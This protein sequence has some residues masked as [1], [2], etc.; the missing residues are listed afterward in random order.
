[1]P[2]DLSSSLNLTAE[3]KRLYGHLFRQADSE[4]IGVVTGEVAVKFFDKTRLEPRIL[5]EI[6]QIADKENRGLL[7]PAGFSLVLRLIGHCQAGREPTPELALRPG[8]LPKFESSSLQNISPIVHSPTQPPVNVLQPQPSGSGSIRVPPLTPEKARQYSALFDKSGAY[9]GVLPGEQAKQI[10]ERAGLPNETLGQIWNLADTEVKGAL[11]VTEFVIAMHLIASFKTGQL[12]V[13]PSALPFGLYEAAS[14]PLLTRSTTGTSAGLPHIQK[15]L[16]G[17]PQSSNT[18]SRPAPPQSPQILSHLTGSS[19]EWAISASDKFKFDSIYNTLDKTNQGYITG[20]EAV[21]F[22]SESKLSEEVLAQIWD[23]ADINSAGRLTKD[24]FAVAMYLIRQQRGK[25]DGRDMLP[26]RLPANLIP[27]SMRNQVRPTIISTIPVFD[28]PLPKLAKSATEDLFGLDALSTNIT[29]LEQ[30]PQATGNSLSL[31][32]TRDNNFPG[33]SSTSSI[34]QAT[35]SNIFK[36]FHPS[37]SFGQSVSRQVTGGLD[38]S[39]FSLQGGLFN[40][41]P[42]SEDLLGDNDPEISSKLTNETTELAN[43]S[44]QVGSLSKN[45]QDVEGQ[46][47]QIQNDLDQVGTQKQEFEARLSQLRSLYE[48]EL[49]EVNNL[50]E[51]LSLS[52][53][54]TTCLKMEYNSLQE[55]FQGLQNQHQQTTM[56]LQADQTENADLK[57]RIREVNTEIALIKPALEKFKSEARQQKGL[58][59]INKK[60]LLTNQVE[61]DRL[62]GEMKELEENREPIETLSSQSLREN[63]S[64]APSTLNAK[65]P[66]FR[67]EAS[68]SETSHSYFTNS[69]STTGAQQPDR[70]LMN[71]FGPAYEPFA[72]N[73]EMPISISREEKR[74]SLGSL[75]SVPADVEKLEV[76][77]FQTL[78]ISNTG[79]KPIQESFKPS[80]LPSLSSDSQKSALGALPF[81]INENSI[82]SPTHSPTSNNTP[83]NFLT[84]VSATLSNSISLANVSIPGAFN[85]KPVRHDYDQKSG[86]SLTISDA[87]SEVFQAS[88]RSGSAKDD[89]DSAFAGFGSTSKIRELPTTGTFPGAE[90]RAT[91]S[92]SEFPPIAEL[93]NNDSESDSEEVGFDDDFAP[94]SPSIAKGANISN[95]ISCEENPKENSRRKSGEADTSLTSNLNKNQPSAVVTT[96]PSGDNNYVAIDQGK[97]KSDLYSCNIETKC[98]FASPPSTSLNNS[99]SSISVAGSFNVHQIQTQPPPKNLTED[100]FDDFDDLEDAKEGDSDDDFTTFSSN[101]RPSLE[102]SKSTFDNTQST[103]EPISHPT[104]R[105]DNHDLDV[106]FSGLES[107]ETAK[108]KTHRNYL[109][110]ASYHEQNNSENSKLNKS[111]L[112][113]ELPD[114]PIL[115]KLTELGYQRTQALDALEKYDYSLERAADY[116]ANQS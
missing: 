60:Q 102:Q 82:S 28:A 99:S 63:S 22:F 109:N 64:Q 59:A 17:T 57:E 108:K 100:S 61:L 114:D 104:A 47:A 101:Y 75:T 55:T 87:T 106:I 80:G 11:Q 29:A 111:P 105:N 74:S 113:A 26:E 32:T 20:N 7:T 103:V 45:M 86:T 6:W 49:N 12:R 69:I 43:L 30:T 16:S 81:S 70:S 13:L 3:E 79:S 40:Q 38:N 83:S 8:P 10:F 27:P 85:K 48:K 15:Q 94:V 88:E 37:S 51:R 36:P 115:K 24:E 77:E 90:V 1:M 67:R 39:P 4:G 21:P 18:T 35:Q 46:R 84:G 44:N 53:K 96:S 58:V 98:V 31:G 92:L 71:V 76:T 14:R 78:P 95:D 41:A 107:S 25:R 23:L 5:G 66:F 42:Q 52:R 54:E 56:A 9:N 65:N 34:T 19:S 68:G 50:K 2:E 73:S 91:S 72:V 110:E 116:L 33:I 112:E 62:R 93:D 89:F 97:S